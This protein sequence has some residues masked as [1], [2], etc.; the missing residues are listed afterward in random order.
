[1]L[2]RYVHRDGDTACTTIE[3]GG[4]YCSACAW[5]LETALGQT[6][7]IKNVALNSATR[8]AVI[9]WDARVLSFGQLLAAI[10]ALGFKPQPAVAGVASDYNRQEQRGALRRLIVAAAAGMQVMMFAVALYAGE[11]FGIENRIEHFLRVISLFVCLPIVFYSAR[12]FFSNALR[13]LRAR[14]PGMDLPVALAISAAF[15]A[16]TVAA[17]ANQ[18]EIYFD[19]VAMFV[20]FLG[21]ARYLEMRARHGAED[22]A[23]ALA[24][25]LPELA[26]RFDGEA[27][28]IVGVDRLRVGDRVLIRPGDVVPADA[29]I[30]SGELTI[31]ES[32]LT[33]ESM[34]LLRGPGMNIFAGG[35]NRAGT[36]SIL[37]NNVGAGTSLAEIGRMIDEAKADRPPVALLADRIA[38]RFVLAVIAIAIVAGLLW[39]QV[40]GQRAFEVFLATLVVTCPCALSLATPASLAAAAG[41]LAKR[42]IMLVRAEILEVLAKPAHMVFDKTGTLTEGRPGIS[43]VRLLRPGVD[44]DTCLALAAELETVSEHVLSRAFA[45]HRE[46][47][48]YRMEAAEIHAGKGVQ[49]ELDGQRYRLGSA[50]FVSAATLLAMPVRASVGAESIVYLADEGGLLAEFSIADELRADAQASLRALERIGHR[51]S[52]ASGDTEGAVQNVAR[53]LAIADWRAAL[54]PAD[55]LALAKL[56]KED[57]LPVVMVGDGVNDAPVLAAADASIAIDAGTALARAS[58]D[59]VIPGRRLDSIVLLAKMATRSRQIIRQNIGWA[60]VYNL[61]AV[62]L[63]VSGVLLPWM[64]AL[65]MSLSSLLVVGNALR[66]HRVE[67]GPAGSVAVVAAAAKVREAAV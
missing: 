31:D 64:A 50:N 4:M 55:K 33:G 49:A 29:Q 26:T 60:I 34:P 25:L 56:L 10:A 27:L 48:R 53:T 62:P 1:L 6:K 32:L 15:I 36:A 52:I 39:L 2:T 40:S 12:P 41:R 54:N 63:A 7:A 11:F 38:G 45:G 24:A 22:Q 65:G 28:E 46:A 61:A 13:G 5:L 43:N 16:S 47:G 30:L 35:I 18:G 17:L 58:A 59:A 8:R 37:L 14:A 67:T 57:G 20:L 21:G 23:Q 3:I 9:S 51:L 66:L 44:K 42:G 19:S